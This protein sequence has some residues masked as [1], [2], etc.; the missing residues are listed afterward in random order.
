ML[1]WSWEDR[2]KGEENPAYPAHNT[3]PF[4][5]PMGSEVPLVRAY[6]GTDI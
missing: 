5:R 2:R 4:T 3:E 1:I 6:V